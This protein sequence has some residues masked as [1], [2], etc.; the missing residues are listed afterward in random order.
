MIGR[1]NWAWGLL[2][3]VGAPLAFLPDAG[4]QDTV[5][6][7]AIEEDT[8]E[9]GTVEEGTVEPALDPDFNNQLLTVEENTNALKER[10]FRAKATLQLLKEIVIQ[11][12]TSGS[13]AVVWHFNE[14]GASYTLES[15]SYYLDGQSI[16]SRTDPSGELDKE[17][18]LKL[19]D[20][21]VPPGNHNLT[22]TA[23]VKGNGF[24]VF[25]YVDAYT[26]K[27]QSSYVFAAEDGHVST[28]RVVL[29]E[30]PGLGRSFVEGPKVFF[31]LKTVRQ[32]AEE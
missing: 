14:L 31:E 6:P 18:E 24:G 8:V 13:R 1:A 20:G 4:A 25:K 22:V 2:F 28:L 15:I 16:F 29:D 9:E 27:I 7:N 12:S 26:F 23:V 30:P 11:G 32:S 17:G 3:L 10:V 19:W 5:E 21:A